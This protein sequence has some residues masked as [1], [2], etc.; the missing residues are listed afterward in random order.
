MTVIGVQR[1]I[2]PTTLITCRSKAGHGFGARGPFYSITVA[3]RAFGSVYLA[4]ALRALRPRQVLEVGCGN[5]INLMTLACGFPEIDFVGLEYTRSGPMIARGANAERVL[6]ERLQRFAPFPILDPTAHSRVRVIQGT[7]AQLPFKDSSFDVV[8]T[9]LALEQMEQIRYMVLGEVSRV[10][11]RYAVM[12]E[13]FHEANR[14]L[15]R[16]AYI[17]T[18][19][20]FK[21][22]IA[23]LTRYG[24]TPETI[25]AD[26]PSKT[27]LGTSLVISR[28]DC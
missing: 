23:S 5:G 26:L 28:K 25:V 3:D 9:S 20:Y 11:G 15:M 12:L 21:G 17:D 8:L 22:S 24:L 27:I 14:N 6:P 2:D 19:T 1:P 4:E 16:R 10:T 7:G 13:P 18:H